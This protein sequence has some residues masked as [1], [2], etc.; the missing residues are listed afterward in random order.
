MHVL[1]TLSSNSKS[2]FE[3]TREIG[4]PRALGT[5]R[6]QIGER[7]VGVVACSILGYLFVRGSFRR[8]RFDYSPASISIV[9]DPLPARSHE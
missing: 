5:R 9:A 1:A 6:L 8:R 2:V 3:Q 7:L 4:I